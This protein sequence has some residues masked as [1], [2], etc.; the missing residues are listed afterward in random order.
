MELTFTEVGKTERRRFDS[1]K[2]R[3]TI[4]HAILERQSKP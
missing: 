3:M 4:G 1:Q 2:S